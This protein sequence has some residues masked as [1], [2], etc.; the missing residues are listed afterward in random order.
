[1][2][3]REVGGGEG[4]WERVE[5]SSQRIC[6]DRLSS[7]VFQVLGPVSEV[8]CVRNS[9]GFSLCV[10]ASPLVVPV[11]TVLFSDANVDCE[12]VFPDSDCALVEPQTFFSSLEKREASVAL[13]V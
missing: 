11:V 7:K 6:L 2:V 5:I 4:E 1:M 10:L 12:A 8:E 13:G 3:K 9:L